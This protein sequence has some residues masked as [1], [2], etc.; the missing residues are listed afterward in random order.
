MAISTMAIAKKQ[1]A[2]KLWVDE[3]AEQTTCDSC[4]G[5]FSLLEC[6]ACKREETMND[7][8]ENAIIIAIAG[9]LH[10]NIHHE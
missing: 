6:T 5:K 7:R 1:I 8:H 3:M 9:R 2:K 10:R 4:D